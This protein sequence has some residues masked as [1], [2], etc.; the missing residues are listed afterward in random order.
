MHC[1]HADGDVENFRNS[2]LALIFFL[3]Y[4]FE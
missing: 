1:F 4:L 2:L 3:K